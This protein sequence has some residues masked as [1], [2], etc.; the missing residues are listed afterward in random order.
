MKPLRILPLCAKDLYQKETNM[1]AI[2][3]DHGKEFK[4]KDFER[5]YDENGISHNF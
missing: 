2:R 3:S 5:F 4:N 1:V